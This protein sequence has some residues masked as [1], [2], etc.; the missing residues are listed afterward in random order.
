MVCAIC[1]NYSVPQ[2]DWATGVGYSYSCPTCGEYS[3][4]R[5]ALALLDF[6]GNTIREQHSAKMSAYLRNRHIHGL[7]PHVIYINSVSAQT[8]TFAIS[9]DQMIAQFPK[10]ISDRL[11]LVLSNLVRLSTYAGEF[12]KISPDDYSLFYADKNNP[13]A[14]IYI[15]KQLILDNL[16]EMNTQSNVMHFPNEVRLTPSGWNRVSDLEQGDRKD[17]TKVFIAM[18]FDPSLVT[19]YEQGIA[20]AISDNGYIPI[21]VD[22]EEHIDQIS[23]RII[24]DIKACKYIVADF[25]F[26]KGG[27]YF[28][29]GF[30]LGL[31]KPVIWTCRDDHL[32]GLHF[33]TRQYNHIVWANDHDLYNK[34]NTRIKAIF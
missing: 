34:L 5:E 14:Q 28:E 21:R 6:P 11:D 22:Y 27:V 9:F 31:G 1:N 12:I 15:M 30:A 32:D 4:H 26:N 18:S 13:T 17:N 8:V 10:L 2:Q 16:I 23:D 19:A 33:D 29:A 25:T 24:A 20:K 7:P 3:M